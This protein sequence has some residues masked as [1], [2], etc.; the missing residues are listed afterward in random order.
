MPFYQEGLDTDDA[1][2]VYRVHDWNEPHYDVDRIDPATGQRYMTSKQT[3][4][5]NQLKGIAIEAAPDGA[6]NQ[7]AYATAYQFEPGGGRFTIY[8]IN[9]KPGMH[10]NDRRTNFTTAGERIIVYD[11]GSYPYPHDDRPGPGA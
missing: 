3:L 5:G 9:M 8:K 4:G 6:G 11:E 7:Y 10:R 2:W 1:G